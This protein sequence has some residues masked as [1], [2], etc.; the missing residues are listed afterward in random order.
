VDDRRTANLLGAFALAVADRVEAAAERAAARPIGEVAA[1]VAIGNHPGQTIDAL[2]LVIGLSHSAAVRLVDR[3]EAAGLVERRAG[4]GGRSLAL[5]LTDHGRRRKEEVLDGR[6]AALASVLDPMTASER[7]QLTALLEKALAP[8]PQD[9]TSA[10]TICRLCRESICRGAGCPVDRT[11]RDR[12]EEE[13]REA[14][15]NRPPAG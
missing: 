6:Q 2:R 9:R 3:L 15:P 1:L 11:T 7:A 12:A 8:L 14:R 4:T 5:V 13:D 10:Q